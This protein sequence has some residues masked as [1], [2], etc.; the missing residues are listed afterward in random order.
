MRVVASCVVVAGVLLG[1]GGSASAPRAS[2]PATEPLPAQDSARA[3]Q[4]RRPESEPVAVPQ[5][6]VRCV[7]L[8]LRVA[9]SCNEL[10]PAAAPT[11]DELA[12]AVDAARANRDGERDGASVDALVSLTRRHV[13]ATPPA[14]LSAP[15]LYGAGR[16]LLADEGVRY[17][18]ATIRRRV[19]P[20]AREA[21]IP[22]AQATLSATASLFDA[23]F[24]Q[25]PSGELADYAADL[26]MESVHLLVFS[27]EA[28]ADCGSTFQSMLS[29]Y[30]AACMPRPRPDSLDHCERLDTIAC[31]FGRHNA[32]AMQE[33]GEVADAS[34]AYEALANDSVCAH[35]DGIDELLYNA[36][37]LAE[38][39]GD[40]TRAANLRTEFNRRFP[41]SG[42]GRHP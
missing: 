23:V 1:C 14:A 4:G 5:L 40:S 18:A 30:R 33:R 42:P 3:E 27:P 25:N 8:D 32:D 17:T 39:A 6:P 38:R 20:P 24:M 15:A 13:C 31:N 7:E 36:L 41:G 21:W 26:A 16:A 22:T 29:R 34:L 37:V 35:S 28:A 2:T 10:S 12:R 9:L 11:A 19:T